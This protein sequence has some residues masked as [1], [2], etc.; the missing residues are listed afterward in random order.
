LKT[1][2]VAGAGGGVFARALTA[3]AREGGEV[4]PEMIRAAEWIAGIEFSE[5]ERALMVEGVS[6]ALGDYEQLRAVPLDNGVAPAI[7][8]DATPPGQISG[9]S[10]PPASDL[11]PRRAR[12]ER[13]VE[14]PASDDDLAFLTVAELGVLL[15][16]RLVSSEELTRLYLARL[17]R[18]DPVLRC[19]IT[20]TPDLALEQ[21]R[22]ADR[23]IASGQYLG[24]LHGIPWGAKDLIA[25]P[26]YP[27]TWGAAPYRDQVR[28]ERATVATRLEAAGAVLVA[29]LSVGALAWGD[30]WF[31]ATT[32]NPWKVEQGSS[33]S[34]AGPASATSA[35]LVG[36]A[37]GTETWGSIVSPSAR[38]GVTGLRPTYGRISRYGV[39]ALSWSMDKIGPMCRSAEDCALVLNELRGSD[40]LDQSAVEAPFQWPPARPAGDVRVGFVPDLFEDPDE[41]DTRE[42]PDEQAAQAQIGHRGALENRALDRRVLEDLRGLGYDL[43][44]VK[45]PDSVPI[46]PLGLILT[47]EASAAFDELT[48]S[49]RDDL[50]VRQIADAWPNVFRQGQLIPAVEYV[51]AN[52]I[53]SL[54][55]REMDAAMADV[56]VFVVPSF[57]GDQLLL[58]N[59]TGHPAIALPHGYR[60][61]DGTPTSITFVG[62]L[63]GETDLLQVASRWQEATGH[64]RRHPTI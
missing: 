16:E 33:G 32:K 46:T 12:A 36:F 5:D 50:L 11:I 26:G 55:M 45:L 8:F 27:T 35:G 10:P 37:I 21:A 41:P 3:L 42:L 48:R 47:A 43:V 38:C 51:R 63:F 56:D 6:E 15:R 64:H 20:L 23:A 14:R 61:A 59:L 28:T 18:F 58:T 1:L 62:R 53:R 57:G 9:C 25:V 34:S 4:T 40:G 24:P 19:V 2:A 54:L 7:R 30:V 17:E 44:P 22:R 49:G 39:M 31:D 52:R 29:K 60:S 13:K